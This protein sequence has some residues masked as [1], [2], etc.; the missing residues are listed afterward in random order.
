MSPKKKS[1]SKS[2]KYKKSVV[3]DPDIYEIA[4]NIV[5]AQY[6][7]PSAY[8]SGALVK[9]YKELGGRYKGEY[10]KTPLKRWFDEKWTN[11]NPMQNENSYP[12]YRPTRKVSK[13]TPLT[14]KEV[15]PK[16]L[17]RKSRLKQKIK[18]KKLPPFQS[19]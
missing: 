17:K 15:D 12:V 2:K 7:K 4:K 6:E 14:V 1:K 10:K 11:V 3:L 13:E 8:R 5:Y 9:K 18:S 16:D 19:K